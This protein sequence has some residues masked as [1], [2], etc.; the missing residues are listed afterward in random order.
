MRHPAYAFPTVAAATVRRSNRYA[1]LGAQRLESAFFYARF[2]IKGGLRRATERLA[3]V[4]TG[5][6]C[7][8]CATATSSVAR[9]VAVSQ[10]QLGVSS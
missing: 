4:L 5:R 6:Y 10:S 3:G 1:Q 8:P 7:Y 2:I 9:A